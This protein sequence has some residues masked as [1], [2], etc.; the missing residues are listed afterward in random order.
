MKITF[1]KNLL[2]FFN[3]KLI[4]ELTLLGILSQRSSIAID[5]FYKFCDKIN[6]I[7]LSKINYKYMIYHLYS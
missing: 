3:S 2:E 5:K 7:F 1:K 6:N 4:L